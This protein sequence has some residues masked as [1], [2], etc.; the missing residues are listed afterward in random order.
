M[1][2]WLAI[3]PP[4][5]VSP[6]QEFCPLSSE[7]EGVCCQSAQSQLGTQGWHG[8]F[9]QVKTTLQVSGLTRTGLRE[10]LPRNRYCDPIS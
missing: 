2:L 10:V 8:L 3:F 1:V 7:V 4:M 6:S 5:L 9:T